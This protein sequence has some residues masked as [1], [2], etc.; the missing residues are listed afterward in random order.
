MVSYNLV[1]PNQKLPHLVLRGKNNAPLLLYFMG[2]YNIQLSQ[3]ISINY[4]VAMI[5]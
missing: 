4:I 2:L 5:S 3:V 1:Y